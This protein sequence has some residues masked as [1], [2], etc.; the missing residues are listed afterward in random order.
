MRL[1]E[2]QLTT[3]GN[4]EDVMMACILC[5]GGICEVA[6]LTGIVYVATCVVCWIKTKFK[7]H[8]ADCKCECHDGEHG[9]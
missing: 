5:A 9:K 7:K 2:C 6:V 4:R 1:S 8:K 3:A